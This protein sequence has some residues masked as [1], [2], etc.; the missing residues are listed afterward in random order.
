MNKSK[1]MTDPIPKN[2]R[3]KNASILKAFAAADFSKRGTRE[4]ATGI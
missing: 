3:F 2:S 4:G 1:C